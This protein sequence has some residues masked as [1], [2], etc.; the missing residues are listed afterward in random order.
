MTPDSWSA[1]C[2]QMQPSGAL[3]KG[4]ERAGGAQPQSQLYFCAQPQL[5]CADLIWS[6][7][8]GPVSTLQ[9]LCAVLNPALGSVSRNT[10]T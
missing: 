1:V 5:N 9:G 4:R 8:L 6:R 3:L 10:C 7:H 2:S